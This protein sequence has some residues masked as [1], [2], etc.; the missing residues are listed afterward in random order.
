LAY[1]E[2]IQHIKVPIINVT[3]PTA[4]YAWQKSKTKHLGLI[5]TASTIR[6]N[7]Y[8]EYLNWLG[9]NLFL[10]LKNAH[11]SPLLLNIN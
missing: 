1:N 3:T 2:T 4:E 11:F 10:L 8:Q 5:G 7:F 6:E 9:K